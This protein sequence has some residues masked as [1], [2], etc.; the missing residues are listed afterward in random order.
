MSKQSKLP[1][2]AEDHATEFIGERGV[3]ETLL[4]TVSISLSIS[5]SASVA[6]TVSSRIHDSFKNILFLKLSC[7]RK[8]SHIV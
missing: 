6:R 4:E 3:D 1:V 5:K 7:M 2:N 8:E